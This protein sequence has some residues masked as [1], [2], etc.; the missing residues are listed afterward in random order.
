MPDDI[1]KSE[2]EAWHRARP[3]WE[4]AHPEPPRFRDPRRSS[5][6]V[7]SELEYVTRELEWTAWRAAWYRA[8]TA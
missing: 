2:A 5:G 7:C 3:G 4:E 6:L 8:A 1:L